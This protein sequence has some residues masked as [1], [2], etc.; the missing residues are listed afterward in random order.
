M[1]PQSKLF[2]PTTVGA[3]ELDHRIV[4]APLTRFRAGADGVPAP[5]AVK[6]Y[7]Q[8]ASKGGLQITEG[9]IISQE[10]GGYPHVP[11]LWSKEQ[12]EG[13]KPVTAAVHAKGGKI[14]VQLAALGRVA[15]PKVVDKVVAPSDIP[16]PGGPQTLHVLTEEDIDRYVESFAQAARNANEAG[17]DAVEAHF[18]SGYIQTVSNKR[19]DSYAASTFKFPLRVIEAF[20]NVVGADRVG[21]KISPFSDFQGMREAKPLDTFVPLVDKILGAYPKLAY[22]HAVE[23]RVNGFDIK[24]D[25]GDDTLEPIR[26]LV[27]EKGQGTKFIVAGGYTPEGAIA[28]AE[29]TDDLIAI[30]R[31]FISNPDM[32]YRIKNGYPLGEYNRDTFYS[33]GPVG[34]IDY[35]EYNAIK[36]DHGA[37]AIAP[38]TA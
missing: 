5:D 10:A 17:F 32:V 38:A 30:G 8:R 4:M 18:A 14:V 1:S 34:Y 31:Y 15:D 9:S 21:L 36:Q 7:G 6:Y 20:S 22:V 16:L 28:H 12:I 25:V 33:P 29:A 24:E 11:G 23:P 2:A 35:P 13:W 27:K 3:L 26:Q 19:T 37:D